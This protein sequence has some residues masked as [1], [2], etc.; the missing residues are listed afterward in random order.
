M[1]KTTEDRATGCWLW[2]GATG[3]NRTHRYGVF[4]RPDLKK[5]VSAHRLS[6]ETFVGPIPRGLVVDH[7]CR[8]PMCVNPEHLEP[9][10]QKENLRR[11]V[12]TRGSF[13]TH[14]IHGHEFTPEN[15]G[16]GVSRGKDQRVCRTC[17]REWA[18]RKRASTKQL[19]V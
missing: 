10:T 3:G 14:C 5:L 18:R 1:D 4:W 16:H 17:K 9:V 19:S 2:S 13:Q 12:G 15:T 7:R 8:R 11:G 6:Y